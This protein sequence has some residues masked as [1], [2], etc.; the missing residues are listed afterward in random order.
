MKVN[1]L[2]VG[3]D[4]VTQPQAAEQI[5]KWLKGSGKHYVVTPNLEFIMAAQRDRQFKAILNAADLAVPDSARFGWALYQLA[6][7]NPLRKLVGWPGF[8]TPKLFD[9]PVTTGTDLMEELIQRCAQQGL[10][11]GFLGGGDGVALKLTERLKRRF[12]KLKVC[13]AEGRVTVDRQG[14]VTDGQN[15]LDRQELPLDLLFVAFGQVKQEKWIA[16]NLDRFPAKVAI[17]V[18]GAFDYLSGKVHRAPKIVRKL[19]FEWLY[20][21]I[22]QPWR[23]KRFWALVRFVFLVAG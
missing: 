12:P 9:F 20:R 7:K 1:I 10:T 16:K 18:G 8:L 22:L 3:I 17:G 6:V 13:L 15:L 5:L 2:G 14:R 11:V 19:G 23:L 4:K 21:L